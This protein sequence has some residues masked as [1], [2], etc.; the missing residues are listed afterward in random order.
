MRTT[1][2]TTSSANAARTTDPTGCSNSAVHASSEPTRSRTAARESSGDVSVGAR[3]RAT[4][5]VMA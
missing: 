2:R 5:P 3:R 4:S 1:P